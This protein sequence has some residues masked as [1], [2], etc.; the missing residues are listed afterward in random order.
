MH[1]R[2]TGDVRTCKHV[3]IHTHTQLFSLTRTR[4][5]LRHFATLNEIVNTC[6][7]TLVSLAYPVRRCC[8]TAAARRHRASHRAHRPDCS[9]RVPAAGGR[10]GARWPRNAAA[11]KRCCCPAAERDGWRPICDAE[12]REW[13]VQACLS[14][15]HLVQ[16]QAG[17]LSLT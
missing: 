12:R 7:W 4:V 3:H 10:S 15:A 16:R 11:A 6:Q 17:L 13:T 8:G 1:D 14:G 5:C 2:Q 9:A